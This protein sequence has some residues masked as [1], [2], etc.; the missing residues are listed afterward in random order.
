[1]TKYL[2]PG[3]IASILAGVV[4]GLGCN[5]L[6]WTSFI[7]PEPSVP[8]ELHALKVP[9]KKGPVSVV[10]L[11]DNGLDLREEFLGADRDLSEQLRKQMKQ[12]AEASGDKITFVNLRK[13]EEY[14][15]THPNWHEDVA[16]VGRDL[17]GDYV[18]YLEI[19]S[20]SLF[21]KGSRELFHGQAEI[22]V[23][24][25][26]VGDADS[27]PER[28]EFHGVYPSARGPVPVDQETNLTD[29]REQFLS[30]VARRIS[31]YFV[32]HPTRDTYMDDSQ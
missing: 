28:K 30:Y 27:D 25:Y 17:Q 15:S 3:L 29:F 18:I 6:T 22:S 13:V 32:G 24:L 14:K 9:D 16:A 4:C 8:P 21:E 1:M 2:R 7:G 10:I 19:R 23:S 11:A 12:M 31:W 20:L 5:P 26:H